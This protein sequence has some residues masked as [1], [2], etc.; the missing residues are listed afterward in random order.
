M[1]RPSAARIFV[2]TA[3]VLVA[4]A[5]NSLLCRVALR[6][7]A[8]DPATFT[9]VRLVSGAIVLWLIV[10][11]LHGGS[12]PAGTWAG[13]SS[14]FAYAAA[15]SYAYIS[16]PAGTGALLLFGA[17]NATM[18]GYGLWMGERM[19]ALQVGGFLVALAGLVY[20]VSPGIAAPSPFHAALMAAAGIAW[21]VY[22]LIGRGGGDAT[23]IT[24]GNFVRSVPLAVALGLAGLP[25]ASIDI[26]GFLYAIVSG[27]I[28]SGLGY[29]LWYATVRHLTS[30]NAA[31]AQLAVPVIAAVGGTLFLAEAVTLRLGI[32]AV[33]VLG[34]LAAV[35]LLKK[36][37]R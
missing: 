11:A 28:T 32:S 13:A 22:S 16:L 2:Q 24:A 5:G 10:R 1:S 8:I 6:D 27:A 3:F 15:F 35:I 18:T 31:M 23:A 34:G 4:F 12:R 9:A 37:Q 14:L 20:L 21:A 29:A 26:R 25:W 30:I 17:V 33:A 36:V 19:N 7:T